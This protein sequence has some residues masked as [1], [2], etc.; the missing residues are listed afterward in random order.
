MN[1]FDRSSLLV[2]TVMSQRPSTTVS[3]IGTAGMPIFQSSGLVPLHNTAYS[4]PPVSSHSKAPQPSHSGVATSCTVSAQGRIPEIP[5]SRFVRPAESSSF[6]SSDSTVLSGSPSLA[7]LLQAGNSKP[8]NRNAGRG[9]D[10]MQPGKD[11]VEGS[12]DSV[13]DFRYDSNRLAG[14]H[15]IPFVAKPCD[16]DFRSADVHPAVDSGANPP[17]GWLSHSQTRSFRPVANSQTLT[18]VDRKTSPAPHEPV[19]RVAD[20]LLRASE[21]VLQVEEGTVRADDQNVRLG[22]DTSDCCRVT[23]IKRDGDAGPVKTE[24]DTK[25]WQTK[26]IEEE[27][28]GSEEWVTMVWLSDFHASNLH[29]NYLL[30]YPGT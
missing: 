19:A 16:A 29:M 1:I 13:R 2:S 7:R 5:M 18:N 27:E 8:S 21:H 10:R 9:N 6:S 17:A 12:Q 30:I 14:P 24:C 3:S 22:S 20:Y 23:S 28:E 26:K 4:M 25:E 15:N 11:R